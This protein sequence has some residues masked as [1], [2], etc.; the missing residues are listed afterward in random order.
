MLWTRQ[1]SCRSS[2]NGC[3]T[4]TTSISE[5]RGPAR[6]QD[7]SALMMLASA[8]RSGLT[9]AVCLF[10][11]AAC[12]G[13]RGSGSARPLPANAAAAG[14]ST[15]AAAPANSPAPFLG[16]YYPSQG[17]THLQPGEPDDFVYNSNPPTSGPHRELFT[18]TFISP[19]PTSQVR[20]SA[21]ARTR[22]RAAAVQLQLP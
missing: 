6:I 5:T 9:V 19:I 17:H 21:F 3:A 22:Q 20:A 11:L 7:E 10:A 13:S 18:D 12:T 8:V 2:I 4:K 1:T 14:S 15:T 16:T